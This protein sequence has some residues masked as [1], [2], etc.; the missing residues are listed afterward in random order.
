MIQTQNENIFYIVILFCIY[1]LLQILSNL[2]SSF[3]TVYFAKFQNDFSKKLEILVLKT[4]AN[5]KVEDFDDPNTYDILKRT[6]TQRGEDIIA[7]FTGFITITKERNT[8]Y[9]DYLF[10]TGNAFKEMKL[11]RYDNFLIKKY[12]KFKQEIIDQDVNITKRYT[13]SN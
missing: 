9:I 12:E 11:F 2:L 10:T 4:I 6:Q 8:W 5:M 3:L 1:F 7:F 13:W